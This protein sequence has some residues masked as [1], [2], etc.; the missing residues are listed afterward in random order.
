MR[1]YEVDGTYGSQKTPT[2]V[3]VAE[4]SNGA[5]HY[6]ADGSVNVNCTYD[7]I[8]NGVNIEKLSDHN[9]FT[10]GKPITSLDELEEAIES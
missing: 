1:L 5:K 3:F 6:V 7:D 8:K 4:K 9:M 10:A 2:T